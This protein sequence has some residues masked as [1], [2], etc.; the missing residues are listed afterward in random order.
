[1]SLYLFIIQLGRGYI[2]FN[3]NNFI[4]NDISTFFLM[5]DTLFFLEN[6]FNFLFIGFNPRLEVPLLNWRVKKSFLKAL[7]FNAFSLGLSL[8][9]TTFPIII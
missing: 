4:I 7:K 3:D 9:Y 6:S 2:Y 1:M 5:S 8:N